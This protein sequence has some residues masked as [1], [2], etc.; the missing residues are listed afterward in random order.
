MI[1]QKSQSIS[2]TLTNKRTC[3]TYRKKSPLN[4]RAE[5]I[6]IQYDMK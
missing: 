1:G 3:I 6:G 4:Y 2:R 5:N